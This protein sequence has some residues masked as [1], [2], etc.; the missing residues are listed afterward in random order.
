MVIP[1]GT[2]IEVE[3]PS[4][5]PASPITEA[6]DP[7]PPVKFTEDSPHTATNVHDEVEILGSQ[8]TVLD[9]PSTILTKIPELEVKGEAL[10]HGKNPVS[11]SNFP[12]FKTMDFPSMI[13]EY[14]T[15]S[16]QHRVMEDSFFASL[17]RGYEVCFLSFAL[18][19]Y[20]S[21]M[22]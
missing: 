17:Q 3:Q 6:Q 11:L 21:Y 9:E 5:K 19:T 8:K 1:E 12:E 14:F 18:L 13:N 10:N 2:A 4:N 7:V 16:S 20:I 22:Q 15:R